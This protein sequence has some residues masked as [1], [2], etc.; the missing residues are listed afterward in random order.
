MDVEI[1][2]HGVPSGQ[3]YFGIKEEQKLAESFYTSSNESVKLV[4]E[5]RKNG[6]TPYIYYTYLRYKNI[7]GAGGRSG[8]Y[9]GITLRLDMYYTDIVHMYNMLDIAFKKYIIGALL[10]PTGESYKYISPDFNSKKS[11]IEQLQ[12]GILKL[13]ETTCVFSKFLKIDNSYIN[14]ITNAPTCN[15]ADITEGTMSAT[16]KK[17]SKIVLSPD[18]KSNLEK[19][20]EKKLQEAEGRGGSI[21]MEKDKIITQ[22]NTTIASLNSTI[23]SRDTKIA[24]LEQEV[25]R[26]DQELLQNKQKGDITQIVGK[27]KEPIFALSEYFRIQDSSSRKP[28]P[29][30]GAKNFK[31]GVINGGLSVCILL[32][33][34]VM[35]FA[36]FHTE[37]TAKTEQTIEE[38]NKEIAKLQSDINTRNQE[39]NQLEE[40]IKE[41]S[42]P[43]PQ[44]TLTAQ[45][46]QLRIDV[47]GYKSGSKLSTEKGYEISIKEGKNN[48]NGNGKWTIQHADIVQGNVNS[49]SITIKPDGK[50]KVVLQYNVSSDGF[51]APIPRD[52]DITSPSTSTS[53]PT[54]SA[55]TPADSISFTIVM[56]PNVNEV[57]NGKEYTFT[58]EGY[59]GE[60]EWK[61]DGFSQPENKFARSVNVKAVAGGSENKATISYTPKGKDNLKQKKALNYKTNE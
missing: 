12:Q 37:D 61:V 44:P 52:F 53:S 15:V 54:P 48:Y 57:E 6:N 33:V 60:G 14:Q 10:T 58:V 11:E 41:L 16:I 45:P 26:K 30:F 39:I 59:T 19:E 21:V 32:C 28:S 5:A 43:V 40:R 1:L 55:Q 24:T 13:I 34:I 17:Y 56:A 3:D 38:L 22:K 36:N 47:K 25:K 7:V 51:V 18:Y 27:I 4:V 42:N 50:G 2:L 46:K 20:F 31:L 8:S 23:A 49:T 9:I 29:K 35:N